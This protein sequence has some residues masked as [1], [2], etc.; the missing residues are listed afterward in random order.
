MDK[1]E[2]L[3]ITK[4]NDV[5][6]KI[7]DEIIIESPSI[8]QPPRTIFLNS[9]PSKPSLTSDTINHKI[10]QK[11]DSK[12]TKDAVLTIKSIPE[13]ILETPTASTINYA[14]IKL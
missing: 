4:I 11:S 10:P 2:E 1:S 9:S 13:P 14:T 6:V 5:K 12:N 7:D 3:M 8:S